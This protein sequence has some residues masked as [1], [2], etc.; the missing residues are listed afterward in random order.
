MSNSNPYG[1]YTTTNYSDRDPT[2]QFDDRRRYLANQFS[3]DKIFS[4]QSNNQID[5]VKYE[6][7]IR[8]Q[9]DIKTKSDDLLVAIALNQRNYIS[10]NDNP[11]YFDPN[12]ELKYFKKPHQR[13]PQDTLIIMLRL[14]NKILEN[15]KNILSEITKSDDAIYCTGLF[16][17]LSGTSLYLLSN[18]F[19]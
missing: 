10:D 3:D 15:P 14:I 16:T 9:T 19:S 4:E 13:P 6:D 2:I 18:I 5:K 12:N 8:K 7:L 1:N 17:L 11:V